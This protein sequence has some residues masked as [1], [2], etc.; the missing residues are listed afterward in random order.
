MFPTQVADWQ[1]EQRV[2]WPPI[3]EKSSLDITD[4]PLE[5]HIEEL[6]KL[7]ASD[8]ALDGGWTY[9]RYAQGPLL[10]V[11]RIDPV[12]KRETV[13]AFN[14]GGLPVT[15]TVQTATPASDWAPLRGEVGGHSSG[16]G[17]LRLH[18]DPLIAVVLQAK[19]TIE[20]TTP[21]KPVLSV[22]A[23]P[24]STL[25]AVHAQVVDKQPLSVTFAVHRDGKW[26]PL[27]IDP[28]PPYRAFLDPAQ[29]KDGEKVY[30]AAIARSLDG[31]TAAS[32]VI[33]F[34]VRSR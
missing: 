19:R 15:V 32:K 2:G 8:P 23:D 4:H 11:S 13:I 20:P 1:T 9:V 30:L 25:W 34:T 22:A 3:G 26:S 6:S 16:T 31:Q 24:Q 21:P 12:S 28:E 29:F 27:D 17:N 33:R 18:V 14:S 5:R 7:R 10:V